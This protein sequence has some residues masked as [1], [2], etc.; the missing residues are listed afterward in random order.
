MERKG[1]ARYPGAM[2]K[3]PRSPA[4]VIREPRQLGALRSPE[5]LRLVEALANRGPA[6]ARQLAERLDRQPEA[7]YY[8]LRALAAVGLVVV[9]GTRPTRRRD[10]T[11]FGLVAPR[12]IVDAAQR[13]PAYAAALVGST[14]AILRLAA[15]NYAA[16]VRAGRFKLAVPRRNLLARRAA[17]RLTA[18]GLRHVNRLLDALFS[19]L[20]RLDARGRGERHAITAALSPLLSPRTTRKQ[21]AP[22][23][24]ARP[25]PKPEASAGS[26][27]RGS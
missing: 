2:P 17:V 3:N 10:E 15:R 20:E 25:R 8:H 6:S 24:V 26:K 19:A 23:R 9:R 27:R 4:Y 16:A 11:V 12:L 5:R 13:S 21:R 14:A 22:S 7:L 1:S 18:D